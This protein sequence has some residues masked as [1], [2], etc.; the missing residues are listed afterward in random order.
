VMVVL[1]RMVVV[2]AREDGNFVMIVMMIK[3]MVVLM[4]NIMLIVMHECGDR[5]Q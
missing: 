3:V 2:I 5:A 1:V 4:G